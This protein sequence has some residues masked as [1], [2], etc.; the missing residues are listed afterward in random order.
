MCILTGVFG[1]EIAEMGWVVGE[2]LHTLENLGIAEN[3]LSVFVSDHGPHLEM[4]YWAG[5]AG[6]FTGMGS[7]TDTSLYR[8]LIVI[9]ISFFYLYVCLYTLLP[10]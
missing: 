7:N 8:A 3:T 10:L 1:D 4:C 6:P 5:H 9:V 2:V